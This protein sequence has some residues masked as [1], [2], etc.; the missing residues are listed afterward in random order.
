MDRPLNT[1]DGHFIAGFI[2]GEGHLAIVEANGG[3]SFR[4]LMSL[5]VRDDD[6]ELLKWMRATTGVGALTP[7][8]ARRTSKPQ[9]Q[10]RVQTQDDCRRLASLLTEFE[11]RGRK[12]HELEIWRLGVELWTSG[13]A[14]RAVLG[15]RLHQRLIDVRRFRPPDGVVTPAPPDEAMSGYLHGLLCAEGSFSLAT[16]KTGLAVH[17]RQDERPLLDMLCRELGVGYVR[18]YRAYPPSHPSATWHV[19]RLDDAVRLGTWLE[20]KRLRGR[21]A[22]ELELWLQAVAERHAARSAG[23]R[24]QLAGLVAKFHAARRYRPGRPPAAANRAEAGRA[25]ALRVLR[26]WAADTPG[27]LSCGNYAAAREPEWP[28]RNTITQRFGSWHAALAAAG[29]ADRA[30]STR[31]AQQ[32]R[33]RGAAAHR[34]AHIAAQRERV[35]AVLRF[36]VHIDGGGTLPTAMQF[37]RWRLINAPAT[38]TQ[39]TVYR[40]FPGGW[41]A[42]LAAYEASG[43]QPSASRTRLGSPSTTRS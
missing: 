11:M 14:N 31:T 13:I 23:R 6:V 24:A 20:P 19:T 8:P 30:A 36:A 40:L 33:L 15:R 43:D 22:R 41:P 16:A 26:R 21:K 7:V 9:V 29:L 27:Q 38:P 34:E 2:E 17:M 3:Q 5:N 12:R 25:E 10:W 42:V 37:F 4:C 35:L 39:A 1:D 28:T 18:N 32:A